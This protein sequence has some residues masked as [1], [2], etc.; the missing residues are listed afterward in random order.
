MV[1]ACSAHKLVWSSLVMVAWACKGGRGRWR[2]PSD[3][4]LETSVMIGVTAGHGWRLP[5]PDVCLGL[6]LA[7]C[8]LR[9]HNRTVNR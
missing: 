2:F 6:L 4:G 5:R 7:G 1:G 9:S 8:Q 3:R